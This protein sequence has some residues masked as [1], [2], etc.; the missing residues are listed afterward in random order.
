MAPLISAKTLY[1]ED[2]TLKKSQVNP[3]IGITSNAVLEP[4]SRTA[5][6]MRGRNKAKR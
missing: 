1:L 6:K 2:T 5:M 4:V 3:A